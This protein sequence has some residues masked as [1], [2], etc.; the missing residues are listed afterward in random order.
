MQATKINKQEIISKFMEYVLE[1]DTA[2]KSIYKFSKELDI[3]EKEFYDYYSSFDQLEADIYS[4]FYDEAIK[5]MM[6][7]VSYNDLDAKNELL[8]FYFTFFELLTNNRSYTTLSL[9]KAK[10]DLKKIKLLMPLKNKFTEFIK[11][12]HIDTIDLKE[13]KL[14]SFKQKSIEELA[15]TQFLF[16]LKFWLDDTSAGFEKTDLFIEKSVNASFD[17]INTTPLNNIIDFGK[18]FFKEKIKPQF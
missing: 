12:L 17:L 11:A 16:T 1:H 6:S 15:W 7:E 10:Y 9:N 3:E 2:P 13:E 8:V 14:N 18:F 5:L 4:V